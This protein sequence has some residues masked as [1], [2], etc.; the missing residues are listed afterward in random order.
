MDHRGTVQKVMAY[1]TSLVADET[2]IRKTVAIQKGDEG[3]Y[4]IVAYK[5]SHRKAMAYFQTNV[6]H[7]TTHE[8]AMAITSADE[9]DVAYSTPFM[10]YGAAIGE[11]MAF[12][13]EDWWTN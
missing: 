1:S 6:A 11:E 2:A 8:K 12:D 3:T 13:E 7:W 5:D 9:E 4:Q 10:A